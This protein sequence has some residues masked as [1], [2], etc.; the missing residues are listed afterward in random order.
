MKDKYLTSVVLV[1]LGVAV[2]FIFVLAVFNL[3]P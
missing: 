1:A 3:L 2:A